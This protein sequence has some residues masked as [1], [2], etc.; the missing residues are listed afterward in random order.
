MSG[1]ASGLESKDEKISREFS[2]NGFVLLRNV[3]SEEHC[4]QLRTQILSKFDEL[5]AIDPHQV[6]HGLVQSQVFSIPN[7]WKF[8]VNE[9]VVQALKAI[10]E[11]EY[12]LIPNF[13]V[14]KNKFGLSQVSIA[15]IPIP[16]R[17]GWH[18]DSGAEP[19]DP[20]HLAPDYRFVKCGLY[21]QDNDPEFGGG[22]D[23]APGSHK[24]L[25]RTGINR[26]DGKIRLLKGKLGFIFNN[27]TVPTKKGDVVIFHSFLMHASTHPKGIFENITEDDKNSAHYSS[28]PLQNAKLTLY[29]DACRSRFAS[30]FLKVSTQRARKELDSAACGSRGKLAF[31]D[32]LRFI[33][34]HCYPKEF[35]ENVKKHGI[36]F[37]RLEGPDLEEVKRVCQLYNTL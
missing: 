22:I 32:Q 19:F 12:S 27:K 9:K 37:A 36:Q 1:S 16:N 6:D 5:K 33:L 15:K 26:L 4:D 30:P 34:E 11:P 35:L 31:Y 28:M 10:L 24:L 20:D 25:C 29:F 7:F 21:L 13:I 18:V 3:F 2:E 17:H 14:Q 23:V 8:L